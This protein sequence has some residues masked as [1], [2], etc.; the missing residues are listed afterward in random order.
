MKCILANLAVLVLT[1]LATVRAAD[2]LSLAGP[3]RFALDPKSEGVASGWHRTVLADSIELPG[4]TD[5]GAKGDLNSNTN[6]T[7]RLSRVHPFEGVAWYQRDV[8]IPEAWRGKRIT[9]L[10][11]RTKFTRVWVDDRSFDEQD[12]LAT[13]QVRDLSDA[14]SPGPHRLT[15]LVDSSPKRW[16]VNGGHQLSNDT[17][18]N[19]NGVIGRLELRATEPV[20]LDDVQ[21]HPNAS[22][23][24]AIVKVRIGNATGQAGRGTLSVERKHI[25]VTWE[26]EGGHAE[27][28]V[29]LPDAKLWDEFAPNV[30]ELTVG[31]GGDVRTIRFGLCEFRKRGTQFT[32][33]GRTTFLRGKHDACVFPLTGRPPMDPAGWER[34]F[35]I[36]KEYGINHYRF[37]SWCPP[38]AAFAAADRLGLYL[39][40]ELPNFGGDLSKKP[41]AVQ[42]TLEEGKRI[43][44]AYGNHP[45]FVMFALGNEVDG[46]RDVRADIVRQLRAF[47][48]RRLFAQASN[49]DL[50]RPEF[51]AGDDYWTT[52]RTRKGAEGAVRGSYAHVDAPLGHIQAGPPATTND[53]TRALVN[54]PVPV[55]GHEIGQFQTFPN[56]DETRKYTGVM[57]A[58][59]LDVFRA[60]LQARG[61]LDQSGDFVRASGALAAIC[62]R[63]EI[64]AALR[65]PGFGG[66]QLLDLQD[67]PGQGTALVGM[68]DAFM[69]SKGLVEPKRWREFCCE[70]VPLALFPKYTWTT[71]ETFTTDI[72]VANYGPSSL[73][74]QTISWTLTEVDGKR[75]AAGALPPVDLAQGALTS[76][77]TISAS[78]SLASAPRQLELSL[79]LPGTPFRNRYDLWVYPPQPGNTTGI[80]VTISRALDDD[81][82]K[83]L[84]AGERVLL[85]PQLALLTNSVDGFFASDFWC[86]PMFRGG[87]PPGTFGLLCDPKHPALAGF[88]TQFHSNWQWF[89]ILMHSRSVILDDTPASF[90]PVVQVIDNFD[91]DRNHKLGLIFETKVGP[92]SLLVCTSDLLALQDR[93]EA[94]QLLASLL[95]YARQFAPRESLPLETLKQCL[96]TSDDTHRAASVDR[97]G[98][99]MGSCRT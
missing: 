89:H 21:I 46:G 29:E 92:G 83:R 44:R 74:R 13:A 26:A 7:M 60:R 63:E 62:Y 86:Y 78:L 68:L 95:Q 24:T 25:A 9:L 36:A 31:L 5:E 58:R 59:N 61:L 65:T 55:I 19:W 77:G 17:Q 12:S 67:F 37:H 34:V 39:Q 10:L 42:F 47:D 98:P 91:K 76:V 27:C 23:K 99:A 49:Y 90:R 30:T 71:D 64:E 14:L 6:V 69:E 35:K 11:E 75:L 53:Y 87:K 66:F 82:L 72:K 40:P 50:G 48:P 22:K 43:L 18:G 52:F 28:E 51:A 73:A 32:I 96:P 20:W 54:V 56:F 70:T 93:P 3:W 41:E 79:A 33:N 4:T 15:I 80:E 8:V 57:R 97:K 85:L 45:S 38:E 2:T 94:R 84:A 16:P 88:P 1:Q 81:T